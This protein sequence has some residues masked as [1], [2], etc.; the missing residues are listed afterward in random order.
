MSN[1][2]EPL[3]SQPAER[4]DRRAEVEAITPQMLAEAREAYRIQ[5]GAEDH[6]LDGWIDDALR[7]ALTAA[8]DTL[9]ADRDRLKEERDA[10]I[11]LVFRAQFIVPDAQEAWHRAARQALKGE[12]T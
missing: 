1:H 8:F 12:H 6:Q 4:D 7:A 3:P 9:T 10:L 11:A 2:S 5:T